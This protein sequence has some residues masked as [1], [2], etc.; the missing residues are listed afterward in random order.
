M[1]FKTA[2][3][4]GICFYIIRYSPTN[5]E[6]FSQPYLYLRHISPPALPG[7]PRL[8]SALFRLRLSL[9][10]HPFR[11]RGQPSGHQKRLSGC[12]SRPDLTGTVP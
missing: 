8:P 9:S 5:W 1:E 12:R 4:Q 11:L 7:C 2:I 10:G 3:Y 6:T